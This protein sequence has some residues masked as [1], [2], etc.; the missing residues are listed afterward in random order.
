[1]PP[2]RW[3]QPVSS[4]MDPTGRPLAERISSAFRLSPQYLRMKKVSVPKETSAFRRR[5]DSDS[6]TVDLVNQ[7]PQPAVVAAI[8]GKRDAWQRKQIGFAGLLRQRLNLA[9]LAFAARQR[10][11]II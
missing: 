1:M 11:E 3:N 5:C 2:R 7:Q 4:T 6:G 8:E 10:L 9:D